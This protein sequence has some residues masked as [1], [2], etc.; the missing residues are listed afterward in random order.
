LDE[1]YVEFAQKSLLK[2]VKRYD[3]IVIGRTLSKAFSLAGLRLGYAMVPKWIM[4]RYRHISP[5]YS[6][7][8]SSLAV[9]IVALNDLDHMKKSAAK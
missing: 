9:G 5:L 2:L 7:S 6:I 3:N 8:S 1:A 4:D